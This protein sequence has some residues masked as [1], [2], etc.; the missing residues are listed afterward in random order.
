M[1]D[2]FDPNIPQEQSSVP[3]VRHRRS[4]RHRSEQPAAT[5][6]AEPA[7]ET[8]RFSPVNEKVTEASAPEETKQIPRTDDSAAVYRAPIVYEAEDPAP[9]SYGKERR[10]SSIE[11][12]AG[13]LA[14]DQLYPDETYEDDDEPRSRGWLTALICI[15]L[16]IAL[17]A[18]GMYFLPSLVARPRDGGGFSGALYDLRDKLSSTLGIK[19]EQAEIHL[20][21]TASTSLTVGSTAQFNITT[22]KSVQNV[23]LTDENGTAL[24]GAV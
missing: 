4:D 8:R 5:V 17:F 2:Q 23:M 18:A 16:V 21:Q 11:E 6:P 20:F 15:V 13:G 12:N 3:Y 14:D 1:A 7:Q 19:E 22:T 10:A 24:P 9:R